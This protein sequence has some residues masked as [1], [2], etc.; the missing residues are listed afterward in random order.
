MSCLWES[1]IQFNQ[2]TVSKLHSSD[3]WL[4]R[5]QTNCC[6]QQKAS[7]SLRWMIIICNPWN[8]PS[9]FVMC[10]VFLIYS[11]HLISA[12]IKEMN[13]EETQHNCQMSLL[14]LDGVGTSKVC[15]DTCS[16]FRV[17]GFMP[18]GFCNKN[19]CEHIRQW[20]YWQHMETAHD[21]I[22]IHK[23]HKS[24]S[25]QT[26]ACIGIKMYLLYFQNVVSRFCSFKKQDFSTLNS[27]SK[28][29]AC[30]C[31]Q[32]LPEFDLSPDPNRYH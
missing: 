17:N 18:R 24:W 20:L 9:Y 2:L 11:A 8:G 10:W 7:C 23:Q 26:S 6:E 14:L 3:N 4:Q 1:Q 13:T 22:L 32:L 15:N 16:P 19:S 25:L 21:D 29:P 30:P 27:N 5:K 12:C 31:K 28:C